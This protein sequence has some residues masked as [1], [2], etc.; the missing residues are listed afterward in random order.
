MS[1]CW[2]YG[3]YLIRSYHNDYG[4]LYLT[5]TGSYA[6]LF[7]VWTQNK[8]EGKV[9]DTIEHAKLWISKLKDYP[10]RIDHEIFTMLD[11]QRDVILSQVCCV[12]VIV[13]FI[14]VDVTESEEK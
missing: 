10:A 3:T 2:Q 4:F 11:E 5:L 12:K 7:P 6:G 14:E 9:F 1:E 8:N 13:E